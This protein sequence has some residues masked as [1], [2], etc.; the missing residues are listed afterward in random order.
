MDLGETR[1]RAHWWLA[2]WL[3][4]ALAFADPAQPP[5]EPAGPEPARPEAASASVAA[6]P[7]GSIEWAYSSLG[8]YGPTFIS[9]DGENKLTLGLFMWFDNTI[10][11]DDEIA[12]PLGRDEIEGDSRTA[13]ARLELHGAYTEDFFYYFRVDFQDNGSGSGDASVEWAALGIQNLPIVQNLLIGQQQPIYSLDIWAN[14]PRHRLMLEPSLVNAFYKGPLLGITAYDIDMARHF[15]W[16]LGVARDTSDEGAT[17]LQ[18]VSKGQDDGLIHGRFSWFPRYAESGRHLLMLGISGAVIE[19]KDDAIV[20]GIWPEVY[21][22]DLDL[23]PLA[24]LADVD[25]AY[26]GVLEF[27]FAEGP[28]WLQSDYFINRNERGTGGDLKFSSWYVEGGWFITG[29]Q[30]VFSP[31]AISGQVAPAPRFKPRD[32][33]YGAWELQARYS[34]LDLTSRELAGGGP[35]FTQGA[36]MHSVTLGVN[37]YLN[38]HVEMGVNYVHSIREDLD[39]AAFDTIQTRIAFNI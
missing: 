15:S 16:G 4:P 21:T 20:Y 17:G 11:L 39:D 12:E 35:P 8:V 31:L 18:G 13:T 6:V 2:A 32:G 38:Q 10:V 1:P 25:K 14:Y 3:A 37:W 30:S 29:E 24:V 22:D 9:A 26:I 33:R 23:Y 36:K 34:E 28:W 19:P 5:D 27:R 7:G